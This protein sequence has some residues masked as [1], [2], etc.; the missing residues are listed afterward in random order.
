MI[1]L[2][3]GQK[4]NVSNKLI[5]RLKSKP[6]NGKAYATDYKY[7]KE[8]TIE[9]QEAVFLGTRKLQNGWR[10]YD[11]DEGYYFEPDESFIAALVCTGRNKNP[12][13][14]LIKLEN[15]GG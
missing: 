12:F 15:K 4:V 11:C 2:K 7:W 14:T 5:R 13:Y 9:N 1:E 3:F 6:K 8:L 10:S